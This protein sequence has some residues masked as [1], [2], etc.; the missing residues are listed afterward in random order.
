MRIHIQK[1]SSAYWRAT[2][3]N[4]PVNLFDQDLVADLQTLTDQLEKDA[5]V[6]VVVFDSADP[7]FFISHIDIAGIAKF[8]LEPGPTGLAPW[9]DLALRWATAPFVT[10]GLVRGRARGVGSEFLQ[11]LDIRFAS[12]EK[13][14]LAQIEVGT[15]V[16]PGGGGLERLPALVG[17]ARALEVFLG[18]D[19][20][21][22]DTAAAYG[23]V[24]RSIPDS[25]LDEFVENFVRRV[26]SFD[27]KVIATVKD[28]VNGRVTMPKTEDLVATQDRFFEVVNWPD[29]QARLT[30][31]FE[32]GLQTREFELNLPKRLAAQE[33]GAVT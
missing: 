24:N 27:K 8:S 29:T 6:K 18:A 25:E 33:I 11:A 26:S 12:K 28:L 10:I 20:F 5:A 30:S 13:A 17:R 23:W 2:I 1:R 14:V 16:I 15:G 3:D 32:Q 9:P 4:P 31:L 21:D 19:D 7:D 22:A